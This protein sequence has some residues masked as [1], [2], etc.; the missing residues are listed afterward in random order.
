MAA[1]AAMFFSNCN[2]NKNTAATRQYQAF[3]TR[4]NIQYNGDKHYKETLEDMENSY[5]DNYDD[6]LYVHPAETRGVANVPQPVGD[7][8]RSVEKAQKAIQLHSIK[9][10]PRGRVRTAADREWKNRSEYNPYLHNSWLLMGKALYMQGD[11]EKAATIFLYISRHFRWLPETVTEA[12]LWEAR[13]YCALGWLYEAENIIESVDYKQIESKENRRQYWIALSSLSVRQKNYQRAAEALEN[14]IELCGGAQKTRLRYLL[15]QVLQ[16]N[17]DDSGAFSIFSKIANSITTDYRTRISA[18]IAMSEVIPR[19]DI[20]KE[21][22][23]LKKLAS[24][25]SNKEYRDKLY[26][27]IGN[28]YLLSNDTSEAIKAYEKSV[29]FNESSNLAIAQSELALGKI[30]YDREDYVKAQIHYAEALPLLPYNYPNLEE[31]KRRSDILD[32]YAVYAGNV[33][34]QDSLLRLASMSEDERMSVCEHLASEYRKEQEKL[35]RNEQ[36]EEQL[37]E[38][39]YVSQNENIS[40]VIPT[41]V[42]QADQ[43][44]AWYFYSPQT[45]KTGRQQFQQ[46]WGNR[47]PEDNWRRRN[48]TSV[49]GYDIAEEQDNENSN[50]SDEEDVEGDDIAEAVQSDNPGDAL[51]YLKA[52]PLTEEARQQSD[53]IIIDGL[54]NMALILKNDI[55]NYRLSIETFKKLLERYPDNVHR[56]DVYDNLFLIYAYLNNHTQADIYQSLIVNEFPDSPLGIAMALPGYL[57][58]L[59]RQNE[60]QDS[61]YIDAYNAYMANDNKLVHSLV[62]EVTEEF[63]TSDL[64]PKF[65]FLDALAYATDGNREKFKEG[66]GELLARYPDTDLTP[67]VSGMMS[68]LNSGRQLSVSTSNF[69][70][71]IFEISKEEEQHLTADSVREQEPMFVLNTDSP[72]LYI[73]AFPSSEISGNKMLYDIGRHNFETFM[74][75]DFDIEQLKA[76]D[77][78]LIIVS[79]L[80]NRNEA[81]RYGHLIDMSETVNLPPQVARI[82]ISLEDFRKLRNEGISLGTYLRY[83]E[84]ER[85]KEAQEM[86]LPGDIYEIESLY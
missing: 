32:R 74:A 54:Y 23:K 3:L 25:A 2:P 10:S 78:T 73:F 44:V 53:E 17:G 37:A 75:R 35:K 84:G 80:A 56:L 69:R 79:G 65:M 40:R 70:G 63:P 52:I 14:A 66:L 61:L 19:A 20:D 51:F 50:N 83:V 1:F 11:F 34:L 45:V 30:Y 5:E 48:K 77:I 7:F 26:F 43:D 62:K 21:L 28:L 57:D 13:C 68:N 4:F 76:G 9:K 86:F 71:R 39:T 55:R 67:V 29:S 31:I 81:E 24:Y 18:R 58:R 22:G 47:R 6:I 42:S 33:H 16:R 46:I 49:I 59:R 64:M 60:V 27:A 72:H 12:K 82:I 85:Y 38:N 8:M 41:V 36:R 15:A